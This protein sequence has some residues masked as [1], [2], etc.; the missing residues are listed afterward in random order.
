M[1]RCFDMVEGA[2]PNSSVIWH[3]HNS[4]S[5]KANSTRM[6][7]SSARALVIFIKSRIALFYISPQNEI[8]ILHF[9]GAVNASFGKLSRS[10]TMGDVAVLEFGTGRDLLLTMQPQKHFSLQFLVSRGTTQVRR[11]PWSPLARISTEPPMRL[12][13]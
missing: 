9:G 2:S 11:A 3:A 1:D 6:R 4:P 5:L 10:V 8:Y 7:F 13:R 12:A